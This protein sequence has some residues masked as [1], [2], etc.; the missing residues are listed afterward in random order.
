[1]H[2][3]VILMGDLRVPG[4]TS[5]QLAN[6]IRVLARAGHS[7][8]L[9]NVELPHARGDKPLDPLIRTCLAAG[10]ATLVEE[11]FDELS[12]DLLI[13]ENPRAFMQPG[14]PELRVQARHAL[15]TLHFPARDGTS[16]LTFEP[17]RVLQVCRA[18][19]DAPLLWAPTSPLTRDLLRET[20]PG[21]KLMDGIVPCI[22]FADEFKV[23]RRKI[24]GKVP[25]IGRHSRPQADKWPATRREV[26]KTYPAAKDVEVVLLGVGRD[27]SEL[28]GRF[29][30]NWRSYAFNEIT[31]AELLQQ[32]DFFVYYHHPRWVEAFGMAT[33]E[34]MVSGAVAVLPEYMRVNFGDGA[35]YRKPGEAMTAVRALH[36]DRAAYA[37]QARR[38]EAY[39]RRHY[40]PEAYLKALKPF[41]KTRS[42][43]HGNPPRTVVRHDAVIMADMRRAG[44]WAWRIARESEASAAAG[45]ATALFH[46]PTKKTGGRVRPE[47]EACTRD[48][49]VA[50]VDSLSQ[51]LHARLLVVH[52]IE[53]FLGLSAEI[54]AGLHAGRIVMVVDG[55]VSAADIALVQRL[56]Q[57]AGK[58]RLS[59][60]PTSEP[61]RSQLVA[62]GADIVIE[63]E[64]WRPVCGPVAE[65]MRARRRPP[66]V[67]VVCA[68]A[69]D[70]GA[71]HALLE[72]LPRDGS[73]RVRLYGAPRD[74]VLQR[75]LPLEGWETFKLHEMP[76]GKFLDG[77]DLLLCADGASTSDVAVAEAMVRGMPVLAA[78][79]LRRRLGDGPVY[80]KPDEML[81]QARR[82][83]KSPASYAAAVRAGRLRAKRLHAPEAH[84]KRLAD[85]IGK[86]RRQP[87]AGPRVS[88]RRVLM[89]SQ[90]GVGLGHV[91]RQL[92]VSRE[93][94]RQHEVVFCSMS[95]AIDVIAGQGYAVEYLP[96]H[97]YSGVNYADWH[98]WARAQLDQMIDHYDVGAV[99]L[100]GSVPYLGLIESAA[101]REDVRLAWIRRAMWPWSP[102]STLR[103]AQQRFFDLIIEPEEAA[104][105]L[106][107]GP[108]VA[109]RER[110][111]CV[112]PIRLF[113]ERELLSRTEAATALKLDPKR[114]AMLIQL[115]SG[116]NHDVTSIT[117]RILA[118]ARLHPELQ[119][120]V[121][122]WH[123]SDRTPELW[124]G[125][126]CL[127]GFPYSRYYKAFDFS[128]S[129]AG[130]NSF[131]EILTFGLPSAF[132]PNPR[133]YMD[134]QGT[135]A[136]YAAR[137]GAALVCGGTQLEI[138]AAMEQ[139]ADPKVRRGMRSAMRRLRR[140]NGARQA[141]DGIARLMRGERP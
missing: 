49:R 29:P 114:P 5:R 50:V 72:L 139:L 56:A 78:S 13:F 9:V 141:A 23:R 7:V 124:E 104:G 79:E 113:D 121:A 37:K 43:R 60:A 126:T 123:N 36:R 12:A 103:L 14:R 127:H 134:A 65:P 125:V 82:L 53:E 10:Q 20:H 80:R 2:F 138:G 122:E 102:D 44:S 109:Q 94:S 131:H 34:A 73:L 118:Q 1:M 90:N 77:T 137:K 100:D 117:E 48:G 88:R 106:D 69:L 96:S 105:E 87:P 101:P 85:L 40:S 63:K 26:L 112:P 64:D 39:V 99:V 57:T 42:R 38:G 110:A 31:P 97:V 81:A 133:E 58:A 140:P 55:A 93:L 17:N 28:M 135:R 92:A 35:V 30:S 24:P 76:L 84:A 8:G 66:A 71:M 52:G 16:A 91:V 59:W 18:I 119:V 120:V 136:A 95:Q 74:K 32:I 22:V 33:A 83:L 107:T 62:S 116:A 132:I 75:F 86:A 98:A 21:L 128:F 61:V 3:D 47:I 45:Y 67:G 111:L 129:A 46:A 4:G 54:T 51:E 25:V 70:A 115:G 130:Y 41:L 108:T 19:T 6:E 27:L 89:F 11:G 68:S 15:I